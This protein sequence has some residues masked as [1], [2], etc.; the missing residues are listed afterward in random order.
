MSELCL[1][2]HSEQVL[3]RACCW[4]LEARQC[5]ALASGHD[6]MHRDALLFL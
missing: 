5:L 2:S 4:A 3:F 1:E 6:V